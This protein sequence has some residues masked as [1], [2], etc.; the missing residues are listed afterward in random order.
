MR[1]I[2]WD[3]E[4]VILECPG[5]GASSNMGAR[6]YF[7]ALGRGVEIGCPTCRAASP[8][9]DRRRASMRVD[10]DRRMASAA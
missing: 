5:C 6:A 7:W 8:V 1:P 3:E 9:E 10:H 4:Q 2:E